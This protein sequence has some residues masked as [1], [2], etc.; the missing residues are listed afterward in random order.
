MRELT[1][2][3]SSS[4]VGRAHLHGS[5]SPSPV[6]SP[7]ASPRS[8]LASTSPAASPPRR[9]TGLRV[10]INETRLG[11][12]YQSPPVLAHSRSTRLSAV[13]QLQ[14]TASRAL[15][16]PTAS[17]AT[18]S[19]LRTFLG[20]PPRVGLRVRPEQHV[21]QLASLADDE[22]DSFTS[23]SSEDE[24]ILRS[25]AGR[26]QLFMQI[27]GEAVKATSPAPLTAAASQRLDRSLHRLDL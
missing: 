26:H 18:L 9:P 19:S 14:P 20:S 4:S 22:S 17:R 8:I 21:S 7:V 11:D 15:E 5:R 24:R 10:S 12:V 13:A 2:L 6:P 16:L 3:V 27:P 1:H 25:P 23:D